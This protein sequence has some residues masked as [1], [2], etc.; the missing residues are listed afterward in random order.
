MLPIAAVLGLVAFAFLFNPVTSGLYPICTF[1][2]LTGLYC[3]GC[4]STRALHALL[5]LRPA[6]ALSMNPL[7]VLSLPFVAAWFLRDFLRRRAKRDGPHRV[8]HP[9]IIWSIL[10]LIIIYW[11][12]RN[13]PHYPFNL[14]APH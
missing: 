8:L 2:Q 4:G 3:P 10:A 13:I 6:D 9:A 11:V 14:L 5:H 12:L 7:M 1:H